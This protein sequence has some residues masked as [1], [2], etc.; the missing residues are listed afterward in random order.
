MKT[1]DLKSQDQDQDLRHQESTPRPQTSRVKTKT[2]DLRPQKSRPR[3][4]TS[5]VN[6]KT[7][8]IKSQ[9]QDLRP[10]ES[11]PIMLTNTG[12][13]GSNRLYRGGKRRSVAI[14]HTTSDVNKADF[15]RPRP[16]PQTSRVKTKTEAPR[17]Q[18]QDA[19]AATLHTAIVVPVRSP[20][21]DV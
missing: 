14:L 7:S 13:H 11:R 19:R 17:D 9:D 5:R 12:R 10:Q 16:R 21:R 3:P 20:Q 6:T 2:S 1:S 4:Q 15:T 8:D 18:D